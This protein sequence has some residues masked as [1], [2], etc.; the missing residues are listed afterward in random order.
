MDA[1]IV[2]KERSAPALAGAVRALLTQPRE[3]AAT[4]RFAERF[5]WG[6]TTNGQLRLFRRVLA[7]NASQPTVQAA[8]VG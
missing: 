5:G 7:A 4:R 2:V 6:A 1:G 8:R 3:R